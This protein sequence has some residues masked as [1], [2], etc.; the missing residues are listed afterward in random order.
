MAI[1][2]DS[3]AMSDIQN[4]L[5]GSTTRACNRDAKLNNASRERLLS[6]I[7]DT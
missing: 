5:M 6:G 3:S 4:N 7:S 1:A 2:I